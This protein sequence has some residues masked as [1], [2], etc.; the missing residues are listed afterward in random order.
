MCKISANTRMI[1]SWTEPNL[2]P[3]TNPNQTTDWSTVISQLQPRSEK[4]MADLQTYECDNKC[5]L[6]QATK[7]IL[8]YNVTLKIAEWYSAKTS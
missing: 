6:L 3:G 2:W 5:L 4:H 1:W 7:Y 8:L